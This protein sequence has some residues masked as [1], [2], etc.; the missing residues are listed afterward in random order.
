MVFSS[1]C[2]VYGLPETIPVKEDFPRSAINPYGRTKLFMENIMEDLAFANKSFKIL[3]L[4]YRTLLAKINCF[5]DM[6]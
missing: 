2:T 1:S 5:F 3:L 6:S 4:R